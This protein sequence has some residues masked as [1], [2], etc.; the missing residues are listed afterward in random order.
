MVA[1][2]AYVQLRFSPL[3][4]AGTV[5]GLALV[6]LVPP[7]VA[8]FGT[9]PARWLAAG[10]GR[11]GRQLPADAAALPAVAALGAG[12]AGH[13]RVLHGGH[14]RLRLD[15]H[16]GRGVVWKRRAYGEAGA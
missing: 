16:R 3:I 15:H 6:W 12:A 5:A 4:L 13:R 8:L 14:A 1:R 7:A 2:T 9:G 11:L 10:L